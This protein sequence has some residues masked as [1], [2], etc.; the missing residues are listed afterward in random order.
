MVCFLD[1]WR[2]EQLNKIQGELKRLHCI[3]AF[4]ESASQENFKPYLE[5][6]KQLDALIAGITNSK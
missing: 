2:K 3:E 4:M 1:A 5:D 6:K